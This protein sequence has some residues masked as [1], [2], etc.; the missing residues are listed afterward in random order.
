MFPQTFQRFSGLKKLHK[1]TIEHMDASPSIRSS[2]RPAQGV[3]YQHPKPAAH[4]ALQKLVNNCLQGLRIYQPFQGD[5]ALVPLAR[6]VFY[7]L[8]HT[9][10]VESGFL[11]FSPNH[12]PIYMHESL[13]RSLIVRMRLSSTMHAQTAIFAV[14]LDKSDGFLWLEDVLAWN[15][16]SIHASKTFTERRA[17]LKQFLDHHWMPDA[18]CAGGLT[19]RIANY[20]PLEYVKEIAD[21]LSWSAIDLCPELPDRRRFRIKAAGGVASSLVGELRAVSGLP[22][23][24]E[25]WSA[26]DFCVGRAAVQELALSRTIRER[27]AKEKVYVEVAWNQE[28][29]RFRIQ[30]VVSSATPRSPTARFGQAKPVVKS[31]EVVTE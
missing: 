27:I 19:I 14:S 3:Q 25:L 24:Y 30:S 9:N 7:A 26:E 21:E 6:G 10:P 15:S 11:V 16:Q 5:K 20:K 31:S 22:D 4:E 1:V 28:F 29:E 23:V 12:T 18:R 13:R 8:V 2:Y 17:L